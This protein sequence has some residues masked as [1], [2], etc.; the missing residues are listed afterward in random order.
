MQSDRKIKIKSKEDMREAG[1]ESPD[2]ADAFMLSF[3]RT[4]YGRVNELKPTAS[5]TSTTFPERGLTHL[6]NLSHQVS[7]SSI[8]FQVTPWK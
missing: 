5:W 6:G 1:V 8:C 2:V 4:A 7:N 3:A